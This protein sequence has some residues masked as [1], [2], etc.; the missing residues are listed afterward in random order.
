[1][2]R[3]LAAEKIPVDHV[4]TSEIVVSVLVPASDGERALQTVHQAFGL[5]RPPVP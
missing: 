4:A 1:M 2:F 3:A 5:D